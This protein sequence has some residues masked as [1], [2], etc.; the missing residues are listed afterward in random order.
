MA[1]QTNSSL[2]QPPPHSKAI[3]RAEFLEYL[4]S[5]ITTS[6]EGSHVLIGIDGP[7]AA[8]KSTLAVE[9]AVSFQQLNKPVIHITYD[10]FLNCE[11]IRWGN[12]GPDAGMRHFLYSHNHEALVE[13]VLKPLGPGR[14]GFYRAGIYS[15]KDDAPANFPWEE[16]PPGA[17]VIVH[18]IYLLRDK[19]NDIWDFSIFVDADWEVRV[20]RK[21]IRDTQDRETFANRYN[22]AQKIFEDSCRP[23]ERASVVVFADDFEM[24]AE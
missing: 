21:I 9:L 19:L 10:H 17:V 16:A 2:P 8:G 14:S 5:V 6:K 4:T 3:S 13:N 18:G 15:R 23:K 20:E 22:P 24:L 12:G 11:A 7:V 1:V